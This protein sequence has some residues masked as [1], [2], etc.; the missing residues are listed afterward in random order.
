MAAHSSILAWKTPWTEEPG[1]YVHGVAESNT[2]EHTSTHAPKCLSARVSLKRE[3]QS[4]KRARG[5]PLTDLHPNIIK[6]VFSVIC[7]C[8]HNVSVHKWPQTTRA[9]SVRL[10]KVSH[11]T[12]RERD[13]RKSVNLKF[14]LK[15]C[16]KNI[17]PGM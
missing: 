13:S 7:N 15:G 17:F 6:M 3:G 9:I 12:E 4:D 10:K 2:I 1:G 16:W 5:N 8:H 14:Y 11:Y